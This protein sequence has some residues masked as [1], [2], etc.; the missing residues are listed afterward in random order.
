MRSEDG[1]RR[2]C[3]LSRALLWSLM[4]L[5][6]IAMVFSVPV[7]AARAA[8]HESGK[9]ASP[10][11]E[12]KALTTHLDRIVEALKADEVSKAKQLYREFDRGWERIED[13][14]RARSRASYRDLER[15]M[16]RV[17]STL[18]KPPKPDRGRA[19]AAVRKLHEKVDSAL[20]GLH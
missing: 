6:L 4:A 7:S 15:A 11:G 19:M 8:R 12:L 17:R 13:G 3:K 14:I 5:G 20:P 16:G 18:V 2:A 10:A 1:T 9:V